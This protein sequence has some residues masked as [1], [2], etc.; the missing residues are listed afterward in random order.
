MQTINTLLHIVQVLVAVSLVVLVL[1]QHGKG[2]DAG[3]AFGSG[4]SST[5]F[6]SRGAGSFLSRL[7]AVLAAVFLINSLLLAW[8]AVSA[9]REQEGSVLDQATPTRITA[10]PAPDSG[11][12]ESAPAP[13]ELTPV[14][15]GQGAGDDV[16]EIT[17]AP[18]SLSVEPVEVMPEQT[19]SPV[20]PPEEV[21]QPP[22]EDVP[23]LP[24]EQAPAGPTPALPQ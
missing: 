9:V 10:P 3:A 23:S 5:V 4:A 24:E 18:P 1:V 8:L 13:I 6:G 12:A 21:S 14:P 16:P 17:D 22:G 19:D 7:T 20:P 15:A 11:D 2:A